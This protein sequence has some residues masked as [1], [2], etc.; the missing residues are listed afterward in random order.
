M[1][2]SNQV[3]WVG[4]FRILN[5]EI[6]RLQN[7]GDNQSTGPLRADIEKLRH[8][9]RRWNAVWPLLGKSIPPHSA[10][11]MLSHVDT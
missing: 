9:L 4:A 2:A 10:L 7:R 1:V 11:V 5:G 3:G 8:I 6:Q